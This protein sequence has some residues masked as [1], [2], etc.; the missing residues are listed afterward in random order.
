[1][2]VLRRFMFRVYF[3]VLYLYMYLSFYDLAESLTSG[4]FA[5][6]HYISRT[7]GLGV[8]KTKYFSDNLMEMFFLLLEALRCF[9]RKKHVREDN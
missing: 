9:S 6:S 3:Y 2:N 4:N 1:M 7:F 8:R 5:R